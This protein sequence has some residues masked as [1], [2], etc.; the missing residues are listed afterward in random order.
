LESHNRPRLHQQPPGSAKSGSSSSPLHGGR[1]M[2]MKD[3]PLAGATPRPA[4]EGNPTTSEVDKRRNL[5]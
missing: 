5:P 4:G 1:P 2:G 3:T